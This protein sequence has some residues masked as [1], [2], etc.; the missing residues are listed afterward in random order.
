METYYQVA[1]IMNSAS[2]E[3]GEMRFDKHIGSFEKIVSLSESYL[4]LD[5]TNSSLQQAEATGGIIPALS[6]CTLRCRCPKL[7]RKEMDLL[8][9]RCWLEGFC[10]SLALAAM[11]DCAIKIEESGLL[12]PEM[13]HDVPQSHPIRFLRTDRLIGVFSPPEYRRPHSCVLSN[14]STPHARLDLGFLHRPV[15]F[16]LRYVRAPWNSACPIEEILVD[17]PTCDQAN[18]SQRHRSDGMCLQSM[19]MNRRAP[20]AAVHGYKLSMFF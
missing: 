9:S 17:L 15:R 20:F 11:A 6:F 5:N 13:C 1:S 18:V 2:H 3:E 7:R 10:H 19:I 8:N 12:K 14:C 4:R 16:L